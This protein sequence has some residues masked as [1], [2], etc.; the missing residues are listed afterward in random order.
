MRDPRLQRLA[1]NLLDYSLQLKAGEKLL[2]ESDVTSRD[3][4]IALL[5]GAYERG[6]VPFYQVGDARIRRAWY[7][8]AD[9]E[10]MDLEVGW[11]LGRLEDVD[12][13]GDP[14]RLPSGGRAPHGQILDQEMVH[15]ALSDPIGSSGCR[16][17]HG[18][19]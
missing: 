15:P 19:L 11:A 14:E 9:R 3:L 13:T 2:I 5:E 17:V 8:S 4:I 10:Q 18:G 7:L 12:A 1:A 6:A 16:D